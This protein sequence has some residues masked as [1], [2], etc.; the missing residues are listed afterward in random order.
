MATI[1]A[2]IGDK[3][4]FLRLM[5]EKG[6]VVVRRWL[7][8]VV[9][10][11]EQDLAQ[12][13]TNAV[14]D[15]WWRSDYPRKYGAQNWE[16]NRHGKRKLYRLTGRMARKANIVGV[17]EFTTKR[18]TVR[19]E[20]TRRQGIPIRAAIRALTDIELFRQVKYT[21]RGINWKFEYF[22]KHAVERNYFKAQREGFTHPTAG[23]IP[24]TN[25]LELALEDA[26]NGG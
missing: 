19:G 10:Q 18:R 21:S 1:A 15:E 8:D 11:I 3:R 23:F 4:Q 26:I 7:L 5:N 12:G 25:W 13:R 16:L 20:G 2:G 24:G 9:H 6:A 14:S 22:L 17:I